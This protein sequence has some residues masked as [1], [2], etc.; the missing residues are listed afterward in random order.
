MPHTLNSVNKKCSLPIRQQRM[1][2]PSGRLITASPAVSPEGA[3]LEQDARHPAVSAG[4][5][6]RQ[7]TPRDSGWGGTGCWPRELGAQQR[8]DFS[9]PRLLH[10]SRHEVLNSLTW[11]NLVVFYYQ[12]SFDVPTTCMS[13]SLPDLFGAVPQTSLR[14]YVLDLSPHL[15]TE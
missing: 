3:Q 15:S 12:S 9:E 2:Q 6:P 7:G 14:C 13:W 5:H 1:L 4:S 11:D 10:L 8:N